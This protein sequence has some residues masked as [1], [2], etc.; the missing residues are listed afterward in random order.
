MLGTAGWPRLWC[1][2]SPLMGR[3]WPVPCQVEASPEVWK[4]VW[5]DKSCM[6][7]FLLS[8]VPITTRHFHNF[9]LFVAIWELRKRTYVFTL[10]VQYRAE[11]QRVDRRRGPSG[12]CQVCW[13]DSPM[14]CELRQPFC[15]LSKTGWRL[16]LASE[17]KELDIFQR[18]INSSNKSK[19]GLYH[20]ASISKIAQLWSCS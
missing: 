4:E 1:I 16:L 18:V 19:D 17:E 20:Y 9:S 5:W 7:S 15:A 3:K 2:K 14:P 6:L 11:F 8:S 12:V 10:R 13:E